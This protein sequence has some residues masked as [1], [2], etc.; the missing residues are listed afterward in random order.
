MCSMQRQNAESSNCGQG[1][2][3]E[4]VSFFVNFSSLA[5][6]DGNVSLCCTNP[7]NKYFITTCSLFKTITFPSVL[8]TIAK[9]HAM[10]VVHGGI[11]SSNINCSNTAQ[12]KKKMNFC[13]KS[14][15]NTTQAAPVPINSQRTVLKQ[16]STLKKEGTM[17]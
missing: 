10:P 8:T 16:T 5:S 3:R 12:L 15:T 11:P 13:V 4:F 7:L 2:Y 6:H 17:K 14:I 9:K 1:N